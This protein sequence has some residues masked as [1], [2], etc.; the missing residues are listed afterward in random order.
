MPKEIVHSDKL[1]HPV[2]VFSQAT[3]VPA[4]GNLVFVSG[5]TA[6]DPSGGVVGKGDVKAQ[7]RR[8]LENLRTI[9]AEAG[10]TLDDVVK[11]TVFIRNMERDFRAIH[12]VRGEFFKKNLPASSMVEVSRLVEPDHLIEIEAVAVVP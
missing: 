1:S 2:G 9:I 10:G 4:L 6:R 11:V 8:I 3:K 12:E 7:T 5:L